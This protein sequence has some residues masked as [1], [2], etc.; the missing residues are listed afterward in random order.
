MKDTILKEELRQFLVN[1][2]NLNDYESLAGKDGVMKYFNRVGS[3]QYDPLNVVGRNPDLVLQS[4]VQGY[5]P[6]ILESLLY[7]ERALVDGY[8]K[9]MNIYRAEDY[10]LFAKIREAH[11]QSTIKTLS[12]RGQLEALDILDDIRRFIR[13]NGITGSKDISIGESRGS[14][15]G[16]RKLSSAA[17]DYLY[18]TGELCVAERRGTQ[19]YYDFTSNV[20]PGGFTYNFEFDN[21]EEFLKWYIKRR[22][23]SV[24][25]LWEKSGG[26]WLGHYISDSRKRKVIL[27]MLYDEGEIIRFTVS[28]LNVPF[29]IAKEDEDFFEFKEKKKKVKFLAPLDNMIW[30]RDMVSKVFDFEYRWEV[31]T[32]V[33]KRKFGY[34]VLPVIYGNQF[35]AR[36]EPEKIAPNVPFTIKSWYWEPGIELTDEMLE[37]IDLAISNFADY[38]GVP[39]IQDYF[40]IIV[41]N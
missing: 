35:I 40:D 32:P 9:E 22:I 14:S 3:I 24:G 25:A 41:K 31:Y 10:P 7:N 11:T 17:L 2:H 4:K 18:S 39:R 27:E 12:Y 33:A 8:D 34:Y 5:K 23:R 13:E 1:Y 36:F 26:G 30:D 19:K 16:H 28:G 6:E 29:Y 21:E 20:L 37:A 38:L 15:W